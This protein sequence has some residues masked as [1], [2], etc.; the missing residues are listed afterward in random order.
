MLSNGFYRSDRSG[1]NVLA[2][3]Y[4]LKLNIQ[5]GNQFVSLQ[6]TY[7]GVCVSELNF[8]L[9]LWRKVDEL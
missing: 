5:V 3:R 1:K 4:F 7:L 2:G 8:S 6:V 9:F